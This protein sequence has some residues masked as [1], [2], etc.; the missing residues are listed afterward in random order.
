IQRE[1]DFF[2]FGEL[3]SLKPKGKTGL[4]FPEQIKLA[5][6]YYFIE[7]KHSGFTPRY[8]GEKELSHYGA[9][10]TVVEKN[11]KKA[12]LVH[13]RK[14]PEDDSKIVYYLHPSV[15]EEFRELCRKGILSWNKPFSEVFGIE[16]FD[17]R[18]GRAEWLP[19]D[20]TK[21][22]VFWVE[23][24]GK[25]PIAFGPS[26]A[27]PVTGEI[28][29]GDIIIFGGQLWKNYEE[30]PKPQ[31][32][33]SWE[34]IKSF[35]VKF[36]GGL[37]S[38]FKEQCGL[39]WNDELSALLEEGKTGGAKAQ[40]P[41]L[42]RGLMGTLPHE[43]G[44]TIGLRHN[45]KGSTDFSHMREGTHSSTVMEYMPTTKK[46]TEPG[47]YDL[48]AIACIYGGEEHFFAGKDL[49]FGTDYHVKKD[50]ECNKHDIGDPFEYFSARITKVIGRRD[51]LF[52]REGYDKKRYLAFVLSNLKAM[53]LYVAHPDYPEKSVQAL[54]FFMHLLKEPSDSETSNSYSYDLLERV[55]I[56][57][58]LLAAN[59]QPQF[60]RGEYK[61]ML[62]EAFD[63]ESYF[64]HPFARDNIAMLNRVLEELLLNTQTKDSF[65]F[66]ANLVAY[67][68]AC[69]KHEIL[70][71]A[72]DIFKQAAENTSNGKEKSQ[73]LGLAHACND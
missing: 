29:D 71:R 30:N 67:F 70:N 45:F 8:F 22:V 26:C 35:K 28:F 19:S 33:K 53:R 31:R 4:D 56:L 5:V 3:Y 68:Q 63:K 11:G 39:P 1:E 10:I 43:M 21:N 48:A 64:C 15:P 73:W 42:F 66:R 36:K 65:Q 37:S 55:A 24:E 51:E 25:Y 6:K 58:S 61:E 50:P 59:F 16:P 52:A 12:G 44:H 60:K 2:T 23:E 57:H 46:L 62:L 7:L 40:N 18:D 34:Y 72:H 54:N 38:E 32:K 27:N 14:L 69:S 9:F 17:V 49:K 20:V 47:A 41:D 13:R